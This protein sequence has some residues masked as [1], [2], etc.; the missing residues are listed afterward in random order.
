[1]KLSEAIIVSVCDSIE[2]G[3][4]NIDASYENGI[5]NDT[6]YKWIQKAKAHADKPLSKL[7]LHQR[8]CRKFK[9]ETDKAKL[10][11][12]KFRISKLQD[13]DN[14]T[15][16]IFLLKQEHP[17]EFN[18]EPVPIPN[19]KKLEEFMASEYTQSEIEE[20]RKAIRGAEARRQSEVVFDEDPL[21]GND[22]DD[23]GEDNE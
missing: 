12:K 10:K 13:L 1:M 22:D 3:L 17:Q 7:T 9:Q 6:F 8:L 5:D 2:Q 18:K 20:I 11:R 14:P 4:S 16:L 19:F 21:F 15:G 23:E